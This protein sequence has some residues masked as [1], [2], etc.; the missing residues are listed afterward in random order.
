MNAPVRLIACEKQLIP[1]IAERICH[2]NV[3]SMFRSILTFIFIYSSQSLGCDDWFAKLKIENSKNCE[4]LCV[5]ADTDMST[6]RCP[7]RCES[8]CNQA[9]ENIYG[10]TDDEIKFC[11]EN[12]LDCLRAYKETWSAEKICLKIYPVS[13]VNDES[14]A[15]RHYVWSI[16]L[17]KSIGT[18][19]AETVLNAHE[20]NPREPKNQQAMDLANN[21]LGLLDYQK[22]KSKKI[23]DE[24]ITKSFIEQLKKNSLII[25]KQNYKSTGGLP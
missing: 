9:S 25:L 22:M 1:D 23:T 20:N 15:C 4:S 11:K 13:D 18:I 3:V 10:L 17:A 14:D 2:G 7:D 24:E 19:K 8:L 5:I 12:K 16:L 6:F 21:R